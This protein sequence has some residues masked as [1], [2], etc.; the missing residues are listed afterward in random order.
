MNEYMGDM[1]EEFC[2]SLFNDSVILVYAHRGE[3]IVCMDS[4]CGDQF[5][6]KFFYSPSTNNV[7]CKNIAGKAIYRDVKFG[8]RLHTRDL[9]SVCN[10]S[11]YGLYAYSKQKHIDMLS[12]LLRNSANWCTSLIDDLVEVCTE[13]YDIDIGMSL[14]SKGLFRRE[15]G[16]VKLWLKDI[17][18]LGKTAL[19]LGRMFELALTIMNERTVGYDSNDIIDLVEYED[20]LSVIES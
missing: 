1:F 15:S 13:D 12:D 3:Y 14:E 4:S 2:T 7:L 16:L 18:A 10:Y 5:N 20:Y 9:S 19:P 17:N 11:T 6:F 8:K